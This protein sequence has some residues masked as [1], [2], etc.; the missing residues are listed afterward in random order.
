MAPMPSDSE[1][2]ICPA[3]LDNTCKKPEKE[4]MGS[5]FGVSISL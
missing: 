3:A 4:D 5:K 2:N 1:K